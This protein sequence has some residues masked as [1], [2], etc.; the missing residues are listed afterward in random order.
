MAM[1]GIRVLEMSIGQVGPVGGAMLGDLGAD[2]IKIEEPKNGDWGCYFQILGTNIIN[3]RMTLIGFIQLG[4]NHRIER[5]G[6]HLT[7]SYG[8]KLLRK[9]EM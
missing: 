5:K 3:A 9:R 4:G 7:R 6:D 8:A 1:E 2:V